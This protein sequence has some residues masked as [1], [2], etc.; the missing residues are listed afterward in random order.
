MPQDSVNVHGTRHYAEE[1]QPS[2][3]IYLLFFNTL[4]LGT[5][6]T[7]TKL[8]QHFKVIFNTESK[9]LSERCVE[10]IFNGQIW[11]GFMFKNLLHF[12]NFILTTLIYQLYNSQ[13]TYAM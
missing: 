1:D 7:T 4:L 11:V 2:P 12:S 3:D 13:R 10:M 5:W 8:Y 9:Y 6:L